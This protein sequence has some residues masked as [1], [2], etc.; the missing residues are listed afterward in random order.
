MRKTK[1]FFVSIFF[2]FGK[3]DIFNSDSQGCLAE[4]IY[5]LYNKFNQE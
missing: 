4:S 3:T 5:Q 1:L 2:I